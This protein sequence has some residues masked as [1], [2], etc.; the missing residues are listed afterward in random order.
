M[1]D[2]AASLGLRS[3]Y[4]D[5]SDIYSP[6]DDCYRGVKELYELGKRHDLWE[7]RYKHSLLRLLEHEGLP[8]LS[9]VSSF[10]IYFFGRRCLEPHS[11]VLLASKLAGLEC[12]SWCLDEN[13]KK[14][15]KM[16]QR[17]RHGTIDVQ[18]SPLSIYLLMSI[19]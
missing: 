19:Y 14:D 8:N 2:G 12:I 6:M 15:P 10:R 11:A 16:R 13:G 5:L 1:R 17:T 9:C 18:G 3:L 4:P 7:N